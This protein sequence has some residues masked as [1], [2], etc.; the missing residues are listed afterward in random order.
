LDRKV[1]SGGNGF[2][3]EGRGDCDEKEEGE[4]VE[5]HSGSLEVEG[6]GETL[7]KG[8]FFEEGKGDRIQA[9]E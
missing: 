2:A 8:G 3:K 4:E 6:A 1:E 9:G 5:L 7:E